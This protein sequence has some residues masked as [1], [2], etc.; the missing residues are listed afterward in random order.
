M[1]KP[2]VL[3]V[4]DGW[5]LAPPGPGNAISQANLTN[6]QSYWNSY[7]HTH[8]AASGE[9]VG[10]PYGE[11]GNTET[12]HINIGAGRIVYGDLLRINRSIADSSF[13]KN[14]AFLAAI[15]HAVNHTSNLHLLGVVSDAGV[16]A[17]RE[18]L[19]TL[20]ELVKQQGSP[21]PVYLHLFTDGR[22]APAQSGLRFVQEV[23]DRCK[24]IGVGTV[25][26]IIGRYF[27]MDRDRRWERTQKAYDALVSGVGIHAQS[28]ID[29]IKRS[30]A[31]NITDEFIEPI[32][33]TNTDGILQ[34]RINNNDSVIFYNY[35]IDRPRQLTRAFL[36]TDFESRD[37]SIAFDP[38][39]VKYHHKHIVE[40]DLSRKPFTRNV[41][42][43]NLFFVTM[44]E[45]ERDLASSV[46]FPPESIRNTIGEAISIHSLKQLRVSETEKERFVTYYF[47][48]MHE[49]PFP[50]ED[51]II[52]PSPKIATYDLK[53]EMSAY[54]TTDRLLDR[55]ALGVYSFILINFANPDMVAHTG[56]I[57][58]SI[59]AC[60]VVD[61]CVGRIVTKVLSY[62]GTCIIT[63]DHG[64][65]EEML[66]PN[67]EVDT[68]HSTFPV[69]FIMINK[70]F[71]DHP[72]LLPAGK[73]A[74]ISPTILSF[75]HLQIPKEM[76]G[77]NL[78]QD[79]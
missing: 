61:E 45:Y 62:D 27:A 64:N 60:N 14:N 12:G 34:P 69:P 22:D 25:A 2:T 76:T 39:A 3:I 21:C 31:K 23:I 8:L 16:H 13:F 6:I 18:H 4:L 43:T 10:L 50:G 46:A 77:K 75:L 52:V 17:S 19:F 32:I 57:V 78:L 63:G 53:P 65:V 47:N 20:L 24:S 59:Q 29:T 73:L 71:S 49:V 5:G 72:H 79:L 1:V 66:G 40:E 28:A 26:T 70:A 68:E 7:P 48:G 35:R 41:V 11:D 9:A 36:Q 15:R 30:Y 38:Y 67:G 54:Q 51:R 74:D 33:I 44:T 37:R 55:L 56:N 42:I 58:K